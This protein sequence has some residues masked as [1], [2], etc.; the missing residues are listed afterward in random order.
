[1]NKSQALRLPAVG[2][3]TLV[4][5]AALVLSILFKVPLGFALLTLGGAVGGA[6]A[7]ELSRMSSPTKARLRARLGAGALIGAAATAAYDGTRWLLVELGDLNYRPFEAFPLFGYAIVGQG[8]PPAIA[9]TVGTIYHCLNGVTFAVF[10]CLLL[11]GRGWPFGVAWALALEALMFTLY[12]GWLDL[13][14]VMKEFTVVSV[15]GHLAYGSTLGLLSQRRF[16]AP[17]HA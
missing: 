13:E 11:A 17:P 2:A 15:T 7:F 6:V 10:Y 8:A 12:P 3:A 4:S 14:A 1:M 16:S 9:L 5:G